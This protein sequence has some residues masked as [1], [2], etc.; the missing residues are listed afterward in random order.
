M[1]GLVN[2]AIKDL[3]IASAGESV[4]EEVKRT[5]GVGDLTIETA[6]NYDDQISL[7]LVVAA[8]DKLSLPVADI[9]EAFGRHWV[10][11]TNREGWLAHFRLD[12]ESFVGCLN[13]LDEMHQRV[14]DAMPD[15]KMPQFRVDADGDCFYLDYVSHREGFAPMVLGILNALA[16]QCNE[17]WHIELLTKKRD[18]AKGESFLM[19]QLAFNA[20]GVHD[21]AA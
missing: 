20:D 9:L 21:Q 13:Q 18:N 2:N 8:S 1:Y 5:A 3:V 16:E 12:A 10:L 19:R 7:Q 4:W 17:S 6:T 14:K 15:A 11:Y